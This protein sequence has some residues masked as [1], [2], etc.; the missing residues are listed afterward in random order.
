MKK[1]NLKGTLILLF[2]AFI[3]GFGFVAQNYLS[4]APSFLVN[5]LRSLISVVCLYAL[6]KFMTRKTKEPVFPKDPTERKTVIKGS[7]IC[8]ICF[9]IAANLQQF[10]IAFYPKNAPVEAH[11]GFITALYVI[12]VPII[13]VFLHKKIS[14]FVWL[15]VGVSLIGFYLLC[16]YEG[17]GSLYGADLIVLLCAVAYSLQIIA[18]DRYVEAIGGIRL[19]L[20]QF[21]FTAV[22]S[23]IL[24]AI[25]D[26]AKTDWS[27]IING[28]IPI[29]YLGLFSSGVAYTL[30]IIGQRYAEPAVAS[31]SMS[32]E[33]V[34]AAIGGWLITGNRLKAPEIIGCLLVFFAIIMAQ[35][36]EFISKKGE[37]N[38]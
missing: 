20:L 34:F 10:G 37:M 8:G 22:S 2:T 38:K 1:N 17:L 14:P 32:F 25:F 13:S 24:W 4:E 27:I 3:W 35:I 5:C 36:P 15:A 31:I 28:I 6:Y 23:G 26:F 33:C 18:I 21:L 19:S 12:I 7:V 11:S 9:S 29:L 16:L 30:Q